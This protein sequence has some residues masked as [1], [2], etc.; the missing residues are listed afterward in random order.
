MG[1]LASSPPLAIQF[2]ALSRPQLLSG[3]GS[4][5]HV[6]VPFSF[7]TV[8]LWAL[9]NRRKKSEYNGNTRDR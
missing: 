4:G 1:V 2:T 3:V 8:Y 7:D 6:K 5:L 9:R